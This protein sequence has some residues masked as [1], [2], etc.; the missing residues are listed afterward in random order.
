MSRIDAPSSL[1]LAM[2]S[3]SQAA[4][5]PGRSSGTVTVRMR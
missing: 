2:K 5:R 3:R 1:T 4:S